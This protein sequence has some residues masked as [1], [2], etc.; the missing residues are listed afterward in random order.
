MSESEAELEFYIQEC[1]KLVGLE[2]EMTDSKEILYSIAVK[3]AQFKNIDTV[4]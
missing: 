3:C 2:G 4:K 1:G